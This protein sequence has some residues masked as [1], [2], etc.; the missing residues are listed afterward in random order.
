MCG[1]LLG[2]LGVAC[3]LEYGSLFLGAASGAWVSAVY[4]FP[5]YKHLL[6]GGL[7]FGAVFMATDPVSSPS[8]H[9][10][11]WIYGLFIGAITLVIR[12][13]NPAYPE[14]VMLA[15]ILGNIVAPMI[16]HFVAKWYRRGTCVSV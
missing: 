2:A 6:L 10:S 11:R 3:A 5:A 15:I 14:G 4:S 1:V 7:A 8:L 9:L 13:M 12:T 16:E